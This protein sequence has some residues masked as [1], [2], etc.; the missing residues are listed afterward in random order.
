MTPEEELRM[1]HV[2]LSETRAIATEGEP[3]Y[4]RIVWMIEVLSREKDAY[5]AERDVA[6]A[7]LRERDA[8]AEVA[9]AE[10]NRVQL[11]LDL[12]AL[13]NL[14]LDSNTTRLR[15][16][17]SEAR[18][19]LGRDLKESQ[20]RVLTLEIEIIQRNKQPCYQC[21][22]VVASDGDW[23]RLCGECRWHKALIADAA[24]AVEEIDA[25]EL[26]QGTAAWRER[27]GPSDAQKTKD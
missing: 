23:Y 18:E 4:D 25:D 27:H 3:L 6:E 21:G 24:V 12:L 19:F 1:G 20:E 14:K 10:Q 2:A 17:L 22:T 26:E 16:E 5:K 9:L 13:E 7:K 11:R 8:R 15:R